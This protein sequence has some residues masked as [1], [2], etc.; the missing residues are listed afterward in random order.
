MNL[1]LEW[2]RCGS[3]SIV[4]RQMV[5]AQCVKHVIDHVLKGQSSVFW[6]FALRIFNIRL[7]SVAVSKWNDVLCFV[8][9]QSRDV[10]WLPIGLKPSRI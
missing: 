7:P 9:L 4:L 6:E 10:C 3:A 5:L 8:Q 1:P 2:N